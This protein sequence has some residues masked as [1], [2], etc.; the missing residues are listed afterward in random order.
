[1]S[2]Q[3]PSSFYS[4][5]TIASLV[6][7]KD[8]LP[9]N[10]Y[11]C[12]VCIFLFGASDSHNMLVPYGT[13]NPNTSRYETARPVNVRIGQSELSSSVLSG[14]T[15]AWALHP[16]L[17]SFLSEWNDGSLAVVRDVGI[18]NK[19][20]TKTQYLN[21]PSFVP[22]QLFAHNIQ[23][24]SWQAALPF[25]QFR[26]TGWFGR[27]SN[28]IDDVFNGDST[29]GSSSLSTS[30]A[31]L[32]TFS[33]S[34][35]LGGVY[36]ANLL[37]SGSNRGFSGTEWQTVRDS[38]YHNTVSSSPFKSPASPQ[39]VVN[40]AFRDIF[41][42]SVESQQTLSENAAGWNAS[43]GGTGTAIEAIFTQAAS[44]LSSTTIT[45]P[46][47]AGGS[48]ITRTLPSQTFLTN[49]KNIA[50]IIYSRGGGGGLA[51]LVQNRQL[52]FAGLG[53]F[54]NHNNLRY[55]HDPLLR[56]LDICVKALVDALKLMGVY[57]DVVIFTESDFSRTLRSNGT[58]GTDHAWAGHCFV[59]GGSVDG[60]MY[61]PEPD[62]TLGGPK[63]VS[64]LGRFVPNYSVEQYY[65]TLLKWFDVPQDLI[66]LVLP[67]LPLFPSNDI[68]FMQ[69]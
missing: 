41:L 18:L 35:K 25:G 9:E 64:N 12:M 53:G 27:T 2:N 59:M 29:I 5:Q 66:P 62:Y 4:Q 13:D 69:N 54:D 52:L 11:K 23:Q 48:P 68:G 20:T 1:M 51:G 15:P 16:Q 38:F 10:D 42:N 36:P 43:D 17:P 31:V 7:K 46:D 67:S 3:L 37:S 56:T 61:G 39:N 28:L 47:T 21:D 19:P 50:K 26:T 22:D 34:P 60:G 65:G 32:Q 14:T 6:N 8:S 40:N 30:G 44:T 55:F 45:V 24:L 33:Y 63:D 57:D 49:L 58:Y